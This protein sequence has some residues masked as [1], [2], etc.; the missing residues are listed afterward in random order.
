MHTFFAPG[1]TAIATTH[2]LPEDESKHAV[3]V[4]R[5]RVG[6]AVQLLDGRGGRYQ[7]TVAEAHPRRCQLTIHQYEAVSPRPYFT[8]VAVA[9]TKSLDRLEWLVE[10]AVEVGV[11][12]ISFLRC[13]RSE[14]RDLEARPAGEN[15]HQRP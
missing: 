10:K 4:L 8:H 7:A 13:A 2:P 6:D 1:L 5:L 11:E 14:R 15:R 12:R 9:P 3:R